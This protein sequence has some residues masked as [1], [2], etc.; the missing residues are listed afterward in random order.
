MRSN[1]SVI[2]TFESYGMKSQ[3][4][5]GT[6]LLDALKSVGLNVR[7]DCGGKG[8]CGKCKVI[9]KNT[10]KI[11]DIANAAKEHLSTSELKSGYRLA[12]CCYLT[13]DATIL[14][15]EET[16]AIARKF[17]M[18]G[19]EKPATVD[20]VIRKFH[21]KMDK[22]SLSD[23]RSD[24]LRLLDSIKDIYGLEI[25][26]VDY[27]LSKRLPEILREADWKA[28]VTVCNDSE[29]IS[30][31]PGDK[32][33]EA[34]GIAIDIGTS[35]ILGYLS[36]LE[37][38]DLISIGSSE[39][40]QVIHGEDV[41]SRI[42]FASEGKDSLEE[43]QKLA[44]QGVNSVIAQACK[45]SKCT[46][47]HIYEIIVVGN[48]AM[49]H[50]FL[51]IQPKYL[52]TSPYVPV[53][54]DSINVKARDLSVQVNPSANVHL[55]PLIA[56]FVGADAV[57]DIIATEIYKSNRL[58]LVIDI[59]TN[60]EIILGDKHGMVACSCAS[61]P[62]FE[63]AH[64]KCGMKA[65]TGAIER[66]RIRPREDCK[67]GYET[68]GKA[69]P[70]GIC[71]SGMIDGV[72]NLLK[73]GLINESGIF[74]EN[75]STP[76]LRVR[77]GE[78]EFVLVFQ[79]E[80]AARDLVITQRDI[81]Q[82]QLAKAAVYAGCYILM[83]RRK[84]ETEDIKNV[85]VAGAFGNYINPDNA[86]L[87]GMLP[88]VPTKNIRFVGNAAGAGARMA[89]LSRKHRRIASSISKKIKYLE[90][91][92]DSDFQTEFSFALFLPNKDPS[93]F[94]FIKTD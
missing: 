29:I 65:V 82:I 73:A 32:T 87:I 90:L 74:A 75:S 48:T 15:P 42:S 46:P 83:K 63:G 80:G 54:S 58:S 93:R 61:G 10:S 79:K 52:G 55:L 76:R 17:L 3:F 49:H 91:A 36:N 8:I 7:S 62:A 64:T 40:P 94:R 70:I 18:E 67:V 23:V 60:T 1:E 34:Y 81:E 33:D 51:G 89:L 68:V 53:V 21:V 11:G 14:I 56:G 9:V 72:A 69:K 85:F 12:C 35:K 39:N 88:D 20:P 71:G 78:K 25:G 2:V 37:T 31:E 77:N 16:R 38:G 86:K 66:L 30:V 24:S 50:L 26:G 4:K 43:M 41:V 27:Q 57:A 13:H 45:K 22:P 6:L 92:L 84:V 59:G 28:T 5:K 44:V 19:T 47:D